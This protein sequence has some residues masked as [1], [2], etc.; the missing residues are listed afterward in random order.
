MHIT[1]GDG[2]SVGVPA[3]AAELLALSYAKV[4]HRYEE[5]NI[6]LTLPSE[7]V[8]LTIELFAHLATLPRSSDAAVRA[9]AERAGPHLRGVLAAAAMLG[10]PS[11]EH[12]VAA[13][14]V[15]DGVM[16]D[17]E[18]HASV[19]KPLLV[20]SGEH[21]E[22]PVITTLPAMTDDEEKLARV[23]HVE[24]ITWDPQRRET[25]RMDLPLPAAA[26]TDEPGVQ[27]QVQQ[28]HEEEF[29]LR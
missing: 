4:A 29:D 16:S 25:D 7:P 17:S 19:L 2:K 26:A 8:S 20:L 3:A 11:V 12:V 6:N 28:Q 13:A 22:A 5:E 15:S 21:H 24:G 14:L 9:W 18:W 27:V 23:V 10:L 1:C